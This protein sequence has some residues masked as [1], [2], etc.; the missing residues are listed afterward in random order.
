MNEEMIT[1]T[2]KAYDELQESAMW[3]TALDAAGVDNWDGYKNAQYIFREMQ[4][5]YA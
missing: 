1:I 5:E 4:E 3:E 2:R